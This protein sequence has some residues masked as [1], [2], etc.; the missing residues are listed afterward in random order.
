M[1]F[2][3][4]CKHLQATVFGEAVQSLTYNLQRYSHHPSYTSLLRSAE[5]GCGLCKILLKG[6][7]DIDRLKNNVEIK[8]NN[9][10]C[11][12]YPDG[13]ISLG[14]VAGISGE[15]WIWIEKMVSAP[16]LVRAYELPDGW[17]DPWDKEEKDVNEKAITAINF[18]AKSCLTDHPECQQIG[19]HGFIPTRVIEVGTHGDETV[20]LVH[21]LNKTLE[22]KRYVALSHCWG[23]NM[24]QSAMT[25]QAVLDEHTKLIPL[26]RLTNCFVDAIKITRR[27]GIPYIWIDS[28]CIIQD[29]S[30]D[31]EAEAS[32][33]AAIYTGAYV[34]ISA[35][36]S[37]DGTKGC[38]IHNDEVP[39]I[40]VPLN[41]G[42]L[43]PNNK[44][45]RRYR[46]CAWSTFS[47][48]HMD[49]DPLHSRGWCLQERELSP[50]VAHF[51]RDTVRWECRRRQATLVFPW[52]DANSF[53]G[54]PRIFDYDDT[55]RRHPKLNPTLNGTVTGDGLLQAASEWFRLV[56]LYKTRNLTKELDIL[57]GS[58]G[59]ARVFAGFTPG[60]YHAG[61]FVSHGVVGL[62]WI[63]EARDQKKKQ[64]NQPHRPQ[65]Y[66]APSW[67]WASVI[68]PASWS[69]DMLL[70]KDRIKELAEIIEMRTEL[71]GQDRF[72]KVKA[73]ALKIKGQIRQLMVRSTSAFW[74]H[75]GSGVQELFADI[76]GKEVKVGSVS[77]DISTEAQGIIHGLA[78]AQI[79]HP[80]PQVFGLALAVVDEE[81][82]G[83]KFRRIGRF[84]S[85]TRTWNETNHVAEVVIV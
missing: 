68:G 48:N 31:W 10:G 45:Q 12:I 74:L 70:D 80:W 43:E 32:A 83:S 53:L 57:P 76:R 79:G 40:D 59:I 5:A 75:E 56:K 13:A 26:A 17:R 4:H 60:E 30:P 64:Q 73:G 39:Y 55:G 58:G 67:S 47:E 77:F 69:W 84:I 28:L 49:R 8:F 36:G 52:H 18:W 1:A 61:H 9:D 21:S 65:Q 44:A 54:H 35:S 51:S 71:Q 7:S 19:P 46:V 16:G 11:P 72:G 81:P 62:L 37:S 33:M 24:P 23:G 2:C 85:A 63:A 82:Q 50:R 6:L 66:I 27:L 41:G 78:C 34:T 25:V 38:K 22:D 14:G 3:S 20:R 42:E 15:R 29:S